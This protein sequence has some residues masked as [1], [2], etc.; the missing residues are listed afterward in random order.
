[1]RRAFSMISLLVSVLLIG[2]MVAVYLTGGFG[3]SEPTVAA[4]PDNVGRTVIGRSAARA[5]D[6]VCRNNL[7]QLRIA[8]RIEADQDNTP[9]TLMDVPGMGDTFKKCPIEP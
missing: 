9:Q 4:R 2:I 7:S 1:M 8:I 3:L 5:K 6:E